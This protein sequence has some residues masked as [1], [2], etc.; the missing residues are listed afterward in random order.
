MV[1]IPLCQNLQL[2]PQVCAKLKSLGVILPPSTSISNNLLFRQPITF[3]GGCHLSRVKIDA[4]SYAWNNT[5]IRNTSIGRYCSIA[6][7]VEIGLKQQ[8]FSCLSTSQ[9]F[10]SNSYLCLDRNPCLHHQWCDHWSRCSDWHWQL[11][12]Q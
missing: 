11:H 3:G 9:T 12:L 7:N 10:T 6:H 1:T 4:F 5:T 8:D 2:S